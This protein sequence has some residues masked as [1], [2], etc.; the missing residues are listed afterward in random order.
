MCRV[1][2]LGRGGGERKGEGESKRTPT[3]KQAME[4]CRL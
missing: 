2:G 4:Q 3:D 1:V